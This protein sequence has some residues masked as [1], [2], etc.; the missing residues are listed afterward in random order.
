MSKSSNLIESLN[1]KINIIADEFVKKIYG[2]NKIPLSN[3]EIELIINLPIHFINSIRRSVDELIGYCLNVEEY[4]YEKSNDVYVIK[5]LIDL[6]ISQIPIKQTI[7]NDNITF[8]LNAINDT[9]DT[10]EVLSG[11]INIRK[12]S[13]K[14]N[15]ILFL[16]IEKEVKRHNPIYSA[17]LKREKWLL[18]L[19]IIYGNIG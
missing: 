17:A 13:Q 18:T 1:I 11:S 19:F 2:I 8:E 6:T 12:D 15:G 3:A 9:F 7:T 4:D 16:D 14:I 10:M 5:S